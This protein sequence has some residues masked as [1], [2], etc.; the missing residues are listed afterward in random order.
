MSS[1]CGQA[2]SVPCTTGKLFRTLQTSSTHDTTAP[3]LSCDTISP[4]VSQGKWATSGTPVSSCYETYTP[5]HLDPPGAPQRLGSRHTAP[6]KAHPTLAHHI[7]RPALLPPLLLI[8]AQTLPPPAPSPGNPTPTAF[9]PSPRSPTGLGAIALPS[10]VS[11]R[12]VSEG[13]SLHKRVSSPK[14]GSEPLL[15]LAASRAHGGSNSP[16]DTLKVLC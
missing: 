12:Q 5:P 15:C 9:P 11:D 10:Y 7:L 2:P 8:S 6:W 13:L 4:P 3:I 14:P 1:D 16:H